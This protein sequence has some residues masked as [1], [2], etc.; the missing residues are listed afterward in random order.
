MMGVRQ[1][2]SGKGKRGGGVR[3]RPFSDR[4]ERK[5]REPGQSLGHREERD[6]R[7][8]AG[9]VGDEEKKVR[10]VTEGPLSGRGRRGKGVWEERRPSSGLRGGK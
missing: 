4:D 10:E 7:A 5:R 3:E 1:A 2:G 6:A 9:G 8:E